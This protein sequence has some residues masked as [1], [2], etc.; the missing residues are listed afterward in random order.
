MRNIFKYVFIF[1][2][3]LF[4]VI[5]TAYAADFSVSERVDSYDVVTST[6]H[7]TAEIQVKK[8][9]SYQLELEYTRPVDGSKKQ[10][11]PVYAVPILDAGKADIFKYTI[12]QV[13]PGDTITFAYRQ[14]T[15]GGNITTSL[16]TIQVPVGSKKN[17]PT[18]DK[19]PTVDPVAT[20]GNKP[21]AAN[22]N[23]YFDPTDL[24]YIN[25]SPEQ[26]WLNGYIQVQNPGTSIQV[27]VLFG[28]SPNNL[29]SRSM[30]AFDDLPASDGFYQWSTSFSGLKPGTQYYYVFRN[31][32]NPNL[33]TSFFTPIYYFQTSAVGLGGSSS[34]DQSLGGKSPTPTDN[35]GQGGVFSYQYPTNTGNPG[36]LDYNLDGVDTP[37]VPD[38]SYGDL[39]SRCSYKHFIELIVRVIKFGLILLLPVIAIIAVYTGIQMIVNRAN[40]IKLEESKKVFIRILIGIA[41][42]LLAWTLI[43]TILS[44]V[45]NTDIKKILLLDLTGL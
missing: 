43:A 38:C 19:K 37:L 20:G 16:K 34:P 5:N 26:V 14:S 7:I 27:E 30:I 36:S 23:F 8:S 4:G 13:K 18:T 32:Q 25:Y 40:P 3:V 28:E 11:K 31:A 42:M 9:G 29:S 33:S 21:S 17:P 24:A 35:N 15:I 10:T 1:G 45:V 44:A 41:V 12:D 39:S 2:L 6:L 22:F